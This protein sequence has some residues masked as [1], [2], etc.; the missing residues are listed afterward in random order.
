M[1]INKYILA[2]FPLSG[3]GTDKL[4]LLTSVSLEMFKQQLSVSNSESAT[5]V[6]FLVSGRPISYHDT[7]L[8]SNNVNSNLMPI[9]LFVKHVIIRIMYRTIVTRVYF[10]TKV[11][12]IHHEALG[13]QTIYPRQQSRG[14]H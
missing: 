1:K 8:S 7:F 3:F 2:T 13:D 11:S 14:L 12:L 10:V 6:Y 9:Y 5:G 4:F